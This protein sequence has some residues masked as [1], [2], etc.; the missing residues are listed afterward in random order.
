MFGLGRTLDRSNR[1]NILF[2]C[3]SDRNQVLIEE[4][5][6]SEYILLGDHKGHR[7]KLSLMRSIYE[8]SYS[9]C[10]HKES[11][12]RL[13]LVYERRFTILQ[14]T[15][16]KMTYQKL[17]TKKVSEQMQHSTTLTSHSL[18]HTRRQP[19]YFYRT[20]I[21]NPNTPTQKRN[22]K[23]HLHPLPARHSPPQ[24]HSLPNNP[25]LNTHGTTLPPQHNFSPLNI[26]PPLHAS[27]LSHRSPLSRCIH[28]CI[29]TSFTA[30]KE[31]NTTIGSTRTKRRTHS[32]LFTVLKPG[33]VCSTRRIG[34]GRGEEV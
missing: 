28:L 27:T 32:D 18:Y 24:H 14:K 3:I 4:R 25:L 31:K 20:R 1:G 10:I 23:P 7:H 21:H 19:N 2:C 6:T 33:T 30:A 26:L 13:H 8:S 9:W 22:Y 29:H 5:S 11:W 12:S 15:I 17:S 16:P 34:R